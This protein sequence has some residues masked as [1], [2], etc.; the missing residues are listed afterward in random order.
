[1]ERIAFGT[2]TVLYNRNDQCDSPPINQ[3]T[4]DLVLKSLEC[5]FRHLDT[6]EV[7]NTEREVGEAFRLSKIDRSQVFITTKLKT[8]VVDCKPALK[9]SLERLGLDYVDLYLIHSPF[10]NADLVACWKSMEEA[11]ALGLARAI[12]V[13]NF[14]I[15][16]L[17]LIFINSK[18]VTKVFTWLVGTIFQWN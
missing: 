10:N 14:Q 9:K 16:H 2:G 1:M 8:G 6:A 18:C 17:K 15:E 13:S 12:G 3:H 4:V 11:L 7:Y 5:G